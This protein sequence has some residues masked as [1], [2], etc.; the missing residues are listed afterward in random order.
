MYKIG[1]GIPQ[2]LL[3]PIQYSCPLAASISSKDV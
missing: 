2:T 1:M 3:L